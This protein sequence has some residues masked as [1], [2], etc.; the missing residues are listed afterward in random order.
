MANAA[1][2]CNAL[3]QGVR[4]SIERVEVSRKAATAIRVR[5]SSLL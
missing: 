5:E 4:G 1:T 2:R 3:P